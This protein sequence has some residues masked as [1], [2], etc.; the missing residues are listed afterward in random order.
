V[1][2]E[3][4]GSETFPSFFPPCH[5][6]IGLI[7]SGRR[8]QPTYNMLIGLKCH[9]R[10]I[11][12]ADLWRRPIFDFYPAKNEPLSDRKNERFSS[13]QLPCA[14]IRMICSEPVIIFTH[15]SQ[16]I[17]LVLWGCG[18]QRAHAAIE[19]ITQPTE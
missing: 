3:L 5:S 15:H 19:Q 11:R 8:S 12:D 16:I 14:V 4:I 17:S 1:F 18:N 6:I 9:T 10:I 7:T 13:A 2:A